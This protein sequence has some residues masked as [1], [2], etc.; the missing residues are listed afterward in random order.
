MYWGSLGTSMLTLYA[1]VTGGVDW[2]TVGRPIGD[3]SALWMIVFIV[4][5][6]V[7]FFAML[8]VITGVFCQSAIDS[9]GHDR[10][11]LV[12]HLLDTKQAQV[13]NIK[14]QFSEI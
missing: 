9:A 7:T 11:L 4:Y 13:T 12:K 3:I 14:Q 10:E 5:I 6:S 1:S 2:D 8:N